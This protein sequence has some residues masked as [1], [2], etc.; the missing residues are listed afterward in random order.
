MVRTD[1]YFPGK[2]A[3]DKLSF[4]CDAEELAAGVCEDIL[5]RD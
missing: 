5:G 1:E 2:F 3:G 4:V